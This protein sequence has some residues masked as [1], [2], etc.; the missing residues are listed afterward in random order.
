MLEVGPLEMSQ[1]ALAAAEDVALAVDERDALRR[2]L[3]ETEARL[4]SVEARAAMLEAS[5]KTLLAVA[6]GGRR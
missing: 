5:R 4:R 6:W 1:R 3:A 2:K